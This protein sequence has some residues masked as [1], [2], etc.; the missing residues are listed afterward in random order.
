ML[1]LLVV[2]VVGKVVPIL[3]A[4][5]E[6]LVVVHLLGVRCEGRGARGEG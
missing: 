2:K 1:V 5:L 3:D 6:D 4:D